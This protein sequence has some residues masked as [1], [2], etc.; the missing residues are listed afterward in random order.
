MCIFKQIFVLPSAN[1][2]F[3]WK[4]EKVMYFQQ[5]VSILT[6]IT[7]IRFY[8]TKCGKKFYKR[9]KHT[10]NILTLL[11]LLIFLYR[12]KGRVIKSVI[13]NITN[14]R[15]PSIV[16]AISVTGINKKIYSYLL[17]RR[18]NLI[19]KEQYFFSTQQ[20]F[21]VLISH[22]SSKTIKFKTFLICL[23]ECNF[24]SLIYNLRQTVYK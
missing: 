6:I 13:R 1:N 18:T 12:D 4:E 10:W 5:T 24:K 19:H 11:S 23:L 2:E 8:P 15:L 16:S 3:Q 9:R 7:L 22:F 17:H 21:F 20:H 14:N